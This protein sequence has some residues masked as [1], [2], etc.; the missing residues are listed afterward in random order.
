MAVP[1]RGLRP[2]ERTRERVSA[3]PLLVL[4]VLRHSPAALEQTAEQQ[5]AAPAEPLFV[6][7]AELS[8]VPPVRAEELAVPAAPPPAPAREPEGYLPA[9]GERTQVL[10]VLN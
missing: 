3:E 9:A 8:A 10:S 2:K 4:A 6:R 1:E 7:P 5:P